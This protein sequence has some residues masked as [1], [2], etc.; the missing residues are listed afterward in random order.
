MKKPARIQ[1]LDDKNPEEYGVIREA[2]EQL[3]QGK[4]G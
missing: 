2:V 4:Q 3:A 1:V